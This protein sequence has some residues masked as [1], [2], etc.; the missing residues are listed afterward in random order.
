[1]NT[2]VK[3]L[4]SAIEGT[5]AASIRSDTVLKSIPG[6][7][8]MSAVT[9]LITVEGELGVD[10]S[11]LDLSHV[12]TFGQLSEMLQAKGVPADALS[13]SEMALSENQGKELAK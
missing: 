10:L 2:I 11:D 5:D 7:D 9:F 12:G 13:P 3:I 8:S 1:M 4:A 6:W